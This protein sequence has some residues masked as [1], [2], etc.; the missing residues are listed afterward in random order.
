MSQSNL[1][2]KSIDAFTSPFSGKYGNHKET[3]LT[4][5]L[6]KYS[7]ENRSEVINEDE[8]KIKEKIKH[9]KEIANLKRDREYLYDLFRP[10]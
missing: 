1:L 3:D 10:E 9:A 6:L 2:G 5:R 7:L 4:K 8:Q